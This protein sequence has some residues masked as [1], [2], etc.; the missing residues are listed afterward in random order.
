MALKMMTDKNVRIMHL[1]T[2]ADGSFWRHSSLAKLG[3]AFGKKVILHIHAS[4]FKDFFN[5]ASPKDKSRILETLH[6]ADRIIVLTDKGI[7]EQ[8]THEELLNKGGIY[9]KLYEISIDLEN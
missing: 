9:N 2:A 3:H 6:I 5:E 4:R 7:E 8:G 1:H